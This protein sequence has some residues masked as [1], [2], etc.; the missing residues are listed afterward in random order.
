MRQAPRAQDPIGST[1]NRNAAGPSFPR[2]LQGK[3]SVTIRPRQLLGEPDVFDIICYLIF[4]PCGSIHFA[5]QTDT[6]DVTFRLQENAT[7]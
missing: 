2:A 5:A 7:K 1:R 3:L 6:I 4:G